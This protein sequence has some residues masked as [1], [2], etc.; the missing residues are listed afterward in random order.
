VEVS[1]N[2]SIE[3]EKCRLRVPHQL[4]RPWREREEE[5]GKST[6]SSRTYGNSTAAINCGT[7]ITSR[8]NDEAICSGRGTRGSN[9]T[10]DSIKAGCSGGMLTVGTLVQVAERTWSNMNKPGGTG[11]LCKFR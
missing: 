8:D 6:I 4:L 7:G 10:S 3:E 2:D 1:K 5:L 11:M 9:I